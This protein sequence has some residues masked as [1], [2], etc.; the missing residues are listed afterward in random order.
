METCRI[1]EG[2]G[3]GPHGGVGTVTTWRGRGTDHM[4]G[5]EDNSM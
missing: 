3:Q 1:H 5:E 2:E 4:E